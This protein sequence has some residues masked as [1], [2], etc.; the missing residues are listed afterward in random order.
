[1]AR[2][3][4]Y[5]KPSDDE[6]IVSLPLSCLYMT[7]GIDAHPDRLEITKEAWG[8]EEEVWSVEH[9]VIPGSIKSPETWEA[10]EKE[11]LRRYKREDGSEIGVSF[12]LVDAGHGAEHVLW[13]LGW[14]QKKASPLHGRIRACR[15]SS[16]FPHPIVDRKWSKLAGQLKGH[17]VGGDEAKDM[18]YTRLNMTAAGPRYRH[19]GM[20]MSERFFSQ[21]TVERPVWVDG[22]RRFKNADHQRNEALD[23]TVYSFAAYRL[24]RPNFDAIEAEFKRIKEEPDTPPVAPVPVVRPNAFV[25]VRKWRI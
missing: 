6:P 19:Y 17:W 5:A 9:I 22:S 24:R 18:I 4:E 3:E 14:L 8:R 13:F 10:C 12:G 7:F 25:G 2:R 16:K 15:G 23:C 20:N 11:L 1:M 21:L